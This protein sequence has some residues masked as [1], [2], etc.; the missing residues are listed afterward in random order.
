MTSRELFLAVLFNNPIL[1]SEL[2]DLLMPEFEKLL[3][4]PTTESSS[5]EPFNESIIESALSLDN[6]ALLTVLSVLLIWPKE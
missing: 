1:T 5:D 6:L 2:S 4:P 3:I